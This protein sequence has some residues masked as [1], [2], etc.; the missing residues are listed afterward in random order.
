VREDGDSLSFYGPDARALL[1]DEFLD[2]HCLYVDWDRSEGQMVA[3]AFQPVRRRRAV[4]IRG[5]LL[6]DRRTGELREV[7]Y[8]YTAQGMDEERSPAGGTV[9]FRKLA[10]GAW[11]VSHWRIR[12]TRADFRTDFSRRG[13]PTAAVGEI[14]AAGGEVTEAVLLDEAQP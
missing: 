12:T 3:L 6:L 10:S 7:D 11:V 14:R 5:T 9:E 4:D 8:Q 1:S 13:D 2:T